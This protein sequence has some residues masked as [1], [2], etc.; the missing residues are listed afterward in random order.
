L[1]AIL[2][3]AI[4]VRKDKADKITEDMQVLRPVAPVRA[5]VE[6]FWQRL[7]TRKARVKKPNMK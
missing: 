2:S 6:P 4:G 5:M 3:E 7:K 1:S